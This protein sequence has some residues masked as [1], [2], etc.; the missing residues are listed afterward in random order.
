MTSIVFGI[1][2][3]AT[4]AIAVSAVAQEAVSSGA[5]V[6]LTVYEMAAGVIAAG[7]TWLM[8]WIGK[9]IASGVKN[10]YVS[11]MLVRLDDSVFEA[12]IAVNQTMKTMIGKARDPG[13]PGGTSITVAEADLLKEA[14]WSHVKSYWGSKGIKKIAAIAGFGGAFGIGKPDAAGFESMVKNKIE[15]AVGTV[16]VSANPK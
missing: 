11:G 2:F 16:K 6:G 10:D 7:L 3:L 8:G 15:A 4:M 13:S 9:K 5:Q 12:V 1:S 14:A